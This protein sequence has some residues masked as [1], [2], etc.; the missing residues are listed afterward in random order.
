MIV[1][2]EQ[3]GDDLVLPIPD[4]V[5]EDLSWVEGDTLEWI[6]NGDGTLTLK[7]V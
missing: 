5:L 3:D 6:D 2:L 1:T 7:K 4:E